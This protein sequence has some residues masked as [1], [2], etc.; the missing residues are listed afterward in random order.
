MIQ[1]RLIGHRFRSTQLRQ[2]DLEDMMSVQR[3][4]G[5][6]IATGKVCHIFVWWALW[7]GVVHGQVRQPQP[8]KQVYGVDRTKVPSAIERVKSGNYVGVD[9]DLIA[10]ARAIE[11][12]PDLEKQFVLNK[13]P[14]R[15]AKIAQ[16][17]VKLEDK[18]SIYCSPTA[19]RSSA[20]TQ[21]GCSKV[22]GNGRLSTY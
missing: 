21:V 12:I 1:I 16:A 17:L 7:A 18:D 14:L 4:L 15:K 5:N 20:R 3:N 13:D 22:S 8:D 19:A 9:I 10:E 11:A 6:G 2:S